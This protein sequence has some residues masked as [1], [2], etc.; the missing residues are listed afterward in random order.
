MI[1]LAAAALF[2]LA[3]GAQVQ[4][5]NVPAAPFPIQVIQP[6]GDTLTIRLHGDERFHYATTL[7]NYTIMQNKKGYYCYAY[8]THKGDL[9]LSKKKA[10]NAEK[11]T[12][13]EMKFLEKEVPQR[14][15]AFVEE[16]KE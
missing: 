11:R 16:E 14:G 10:H 6:N 13:K 3:A 7:D 15:K 5:Q 2:S 8:F 4:K 12:E 1:I 9:T